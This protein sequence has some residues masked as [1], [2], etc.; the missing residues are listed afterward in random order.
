MDYHCDNRENVLSISVT[1]CELM[2][3]EQQ[4]L[5]IWVTPTSN[6]GIAECYIAWNKKYMYDYVIAT[7]WD[8]LDEVGMD[9]TGIEDMTEEEYKITSEAVGQDVYT[10][11]WILI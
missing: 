2:D 8:L 3:M 11:Q 7:C 4:G 6:G 9:S 10:L 1:F 5:K